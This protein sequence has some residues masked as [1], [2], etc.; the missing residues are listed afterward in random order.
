MLVSDHDADNTPANLMLTLSGLSEEE[1]LMTPIANIPTSA[2]GF[3]FEPYGSKSDGLRPFLMA[4]AA[5]F[6]F[7]RNASH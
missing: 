3:L 5:R 6:D 2:S 4:P 7:N 1:A